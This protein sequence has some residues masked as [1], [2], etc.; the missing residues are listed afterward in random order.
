M[1]GGAAHRDRRL[2]WRSGRLALP[3]QVIATSSEP[4]SPQNLRGR[5]ASVA[6]RVVPLLLVALL[7]GVAAVATVGIGRPTEGELGP[8]RVELRARWGLNGRTQL[9]LPPLGAISAA[10]HDA[11]LAV[12]LRVQRLDVERVQDLLARPDPEIRL[13]QSLSSDLE[14]LVARFARQ[15][16]LTSLLVGVVVGAVLPRRR[17]NWVVAGGAG[18]V[19]AVSALLGRAWATYDEDAFVNPRFEGSLERAPD[20]LRTVQRHVEGFD[21]IRGRVEVLSQQVANLYRATVMGPEDD[22]DAVAILHVSD[23]HSNPLAVEVVRQLAS[24]FEVDAVLDTGDVTSFGLPLEARIGDLIAGIPVPYYL[25]PG[26]HDSN[27]VRSALAA[28]PNVTVLAGA[29]VDIGGVRVLGVA[30]PTFTADNGVGTADAA[31]EKRRQASAV[32]RLTAARRPD[33]LAVHDPALAEEAAGR[34]PLVVAGHRHERSSE[35]RDGTRY[36]TVGSTGATG[37]GSFTVATQLDYEAQVLH[38]SEGR[39]VVVDYV[40]LGGISGSFRI[41]RTVVDP[42]EEVVDPREE[43]DSEAQP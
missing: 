8:G 20:I 29:V 17:W 35:V 2:R 28:V 32:G 33:V 14:P 22:D 3:S 11:P 18:G 26:N 16:L 38:F 5:A 7:A 12:D 13:R 24:R 40:S 15:A 30:D 27:A 43:D 41:E 10:T 42:R 6:R 34:V 36:L 19:L 23:V 25:T 37:L 1:A 9:G 31:A 39:L 21:D 4:R